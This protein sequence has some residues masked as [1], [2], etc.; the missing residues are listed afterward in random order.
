MKTLKSISLFSSITLSL[1]MF[2]TLHSHAGLIES[3]FE[4]SYEVSHNSF[5]LG[6]SVRNLVKQDNQT[7]IYRSDTSPKGIAKAFVS[8]V[9]E[10][11]STINRNVG[12]FYPVE[13]KYR[14]HGGKK[15]TEFTLNY[16]W[17]A[18]KLTN[19]YNKQTY[20]LKPDTHDLLSFQIQL[21][22]DLQAGKNKVSYVIADKKR[23]DTYNLKADKKESI[24]TPMKTFSAIKL[25]SNKIRNKMQFIIWCAPELGYL[26]VKVMK[27]EEDG[28]KSIVVLKSI[29][30]N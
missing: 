9:I 1:S 20:E 12:Q 4:A 15:L 2:V 6:D 24:E 8:D 16:D 28:D 19:T 29:K 10:E 22:H 7:W 13:Y 11:I 26:P 5:Y 21:M 27:I 25:V 17:A 30:I 14:Q 18:N 23:V 3:G